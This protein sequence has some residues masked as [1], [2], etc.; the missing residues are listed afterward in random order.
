MYYAEQIQ[1]NSDFS[2]L[3]N[4]QLLESIA[5]MKEK[6]AY[7]HSRELVRLERLKAKAIISNIDLYQTIRDQY[8]QTRSTPPHVWFEGWEIYISILK[9]AEK[10]NLFALE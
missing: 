2:N 1:N 6:A 3:S 5:V 10:R 8:N 4:S 9:E 7:F